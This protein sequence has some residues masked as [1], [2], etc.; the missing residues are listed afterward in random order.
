MKKLLLVISLLASLFS[1]MNNTSIDKLWKD[2]E[3]ARKA[4]KPQRQMEILSSIKETAV[5]ERLPWDF[6]SAGNKYVRVATSRNWKLR[7]SLDKSWREEILAFDEPILTFYHGLDGEA[8]RRDYAFAHKKALQKAHN[9]DF[10]A[11]DGYLTSRKFSPVLVEL[12]ENDWQGVLWSLTL[13]SR[14]DEESRAALSETLGG[15]YPQADFLEFARISAIHDDFSRKSEYL[16]F[17]QD[18]PGKAAA[19]LA[20]DE[21][22]QMEFA[23]LQ[24]EGAGEERYRALRQKCVD[25]QK[26]CKDFNGSE[27]KI[28]SC[29]TLAG[30]LLKTL[31]SKSLDINVEKGELVAVL[32]NLDSFEVTLSQGRTDI[33]KT[34]V[35]NPKR[36]FYVP[37]TLTL[38]LPD[39]PDGVYDVLCSSGKDISQYVTYDKYS[40][41]IARRRDASGLWILVTDA[42][43]G[44]PL[45]SADLVAKNSDGKTLASLEDFALDGY[46]LLPQAFASSLEG[47]SVRSPRIVASCTDAKGIV[48]SSKPLYP[49]AASEKSDRVSQEI[50][51][52]TDR[53]AFNP[54]DTVQFKVIVYQE[55]ADG[56]R[57]LV[58]LGTKVTVRL[59]DASGDE[60][61][62]VTLETGDFGSAAGSFVIPRSERN[63]RYSLN[64]ETDDAYSYRSIVVDDFV[65]P[66]FTLVFDEDGHLYHPGEKVEVTGTIRSYSGHSVSAARVEAQVSHY[67]EVL[68][69][70]TPI[71]GE[72]GRFSLSFVCDSEGYSV[73][74]VTVKV[75]DS[76]GETLEWSTQRRFYDDIPL[77]VSI[78]RHSD[79]EYLSRADD[80]TL[81]S[82]DTL[83]SSGTIIS[84]DTL[85]LHLQADFMERDGL[86]ARYAIFKS[87]AL[88]GSADGSSSAPAAPSST[89][90]SGSLSSTIQGSPSSAIPV[91]EGRTT[92][93]DSV[94]VDISSLPDGLYTLRCTASD[95]DAFGNVRSAER[96]QTFLL[97]R[98]GSSAFDGDLEYVFKVE[99]SVSGLLLR[100]G[101]G[102]GTGAGFGSGSGAGTGSGSG[103]VSGS[104]SGSGADALTVQ[105]GTSHYPMWAF[106]DLHDDRGVLLGSRLVHFDSP[107]SSTDAASAAATSA[108]C[109]VASAT[110]PATLASSA[111]GSSSAVSSAS[112]ASSPS[113]VETAGGAIGGASGRV[114]TVRFSLEGVSTG[115]IMLSVRYFRDFQQYSWSYTGRFFSATDELPLRFSR[116]RDRTSPGET[117]SLELQTEPGVECAAAVFD[118]STETVKSNAWNRLRSRSA[119]TI[120]V[121]YDGVAGVD[122]SRYSRLYAN[123]GRVMMAKSAA[124][125]SDEMLL[126]EAE[127]TFAEALP[128]AL[129]DALPDAVGSLAYS[130]DSGSADAL[131][132]RE[133]F[134]N[135]LAFKPFLRSDD[136]GK[137]SFDFTAAD[138]LSTYIVQIFA[139]TRELRSAVVRREAVVTI[140]VKVS[141]VEPQYLYAGDRYTLSASL[142]S[143]FD[144]PVT[145]LLRVDF[146]DG[147]DYKAVAPLY[148]LSRTVTV[149]AGGALGEAFDLG[150]VP[151][152]PALHSGLL[153]IKVSFVA[154]RIVEVSSGSS[155]DASSEV[156]DGVSSR[157][158]A[159]V[160]CSD[161]VFVTVPVLPA[162][163]TITEAHSSL[164]H[165]GESMDSLALQLRSE[166]VGVSGDAASVRT[167]SLLD[168]VR[169]AIPSRVEATS[170]NALALSEALY[171]RALAARLSSRGSGSRSASGSGLGLVASGSGSGSVSGSGSGSAPGDPSTSDALLSKLM[172]CRRADGGFSWFST[173]D[174]SP[175]VTAALLYR[176]ASARDRGMLS[177]AAGSTGSG[178]DYSFIPREVIE[179]AVR[180]LDRSYFG[181]DLPFWR[182]ALSMQQY[183][184]VR[185]LFASVPFD[186]SDFNRL[187][188]KDFAKDAREF[189]VPSSDRGLQGRILAKARRMRVL[190]ALSSSDDGLAL[191]RAFGIKLLTTKRLQTSL[192]RDLA[193][194]EEYAVQHR[195]G[196][197]Y[198]PNAVLPW[199]GLLESEAF[200]H[201]YI[202]DLL[203]DIAAASAD[204]GSVSVASAGSRSGDGLSSGALPGGALSSASSPDDSRLGDGL[205]SATSLYDSRSGDGLPGGAARFNGFCLKGVSDELLSGAADISEGIRLWLMVQKETQ[206]WGSDAAFV[207]ALATVLD[208]SDETLATSVVVLSATFDT[209]FEQ[210]RASGNGFTIER[211]FY[212][213]RGDASDT[214]SG[215]VAGSDSGSDVGSGGAAAGSS[216][217]A[218][219]GAS[220]LVELRDGDVLRVGDKVT[221]VYRIWNEENRSFVR[222]SAPRPASFRP[223][224]QLS[225]SFGGWFRSLR[226]YRSVLSDRTEYWYDAYPEEVTTVEESF[227]VTQSG[228]FQTPASVVES[229]YAP[230][231]RANAS[232][233]AP[234]QSQ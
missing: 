141:V 8:A 190:L 150:Q 225:G 189:L 64:A 108:S 95:A 38:S 232:G 163:Q 123:G 221:V 100:S 44:E 153:G 86:V 223:V 133:N 34:V 11:D 137:V 62:K 17:V 146:Y 118:K 6:Y 214:A 97:L 36:S 77:S 181:A 140:P 121:S 164:L 104:G 5:Q 48:R 149:P 115:S 230:H 55:D 73:Y 22:L 176:Y 76:T 37:D 157:P 180:Y 102:S 40:L 212:V 228:A 198:Y 70:E 126:E 92:V 187:R 26:K 188:V 21:L 15:A 14:E 59:E 74:A 234:I 215:S 88:P 47:K 204:S 119:L 155:V 218:S 177:A 68:S 209:P 162:V 79:G 220:A 80:G 158:S 197:W 91:L 72:D 117:C 145:G 25:F 27:A 168:M 60:V 135:T 136:A 186:A 172:E 109:A 81:I 203:R 13:R 29:C 184:S 78:G 58:P 61:G 130:L 110:D 167:I 46:T 23:S 207:E 205:S 103:A 156:S 113:A 148:S 216:N 222:I 69:R 32:R 57:S 114:Q 90:A 87:E 139:H 2:Y 202:A 18:R 56:V 35:E 224:E 231:Y 138:K 193:S 94:M 99:G 105:V 142:A 24:R 111:P 160:L 165:K 30:S 144:A 53:S 19:L 66:T 143:T 116:F 194:L 196:G 125:Y 52:L 151:G 7:D 233:A 131:A 213:E 208:A 191:A 195:S 50:I 185:A 170:D 82:S 93:P 43:S 154:D 166:F 54:E 45:R 147:A 227:Y 206:Q 96:S 178:S 71:V 161:A 75:T 3:S 33:F 28:A 49:G 174:S 183:L 106:V 98:D 132:V 175:I 63:G 128:N 41:S 226:G 122:R 199:R 192:A 134:A 229:L 124:F 101:S 127:G 12:L 4:D 200:A 169:E 51:I 65:L 173:M 39:L 217:S 42:L 120:P 67:G 31:G 211:R 182:G 107:L 129:P 201:S 179:A 84:S 9:A 159:P 210:V 89:S 219:N 112:S 171:V 83:I 1:G 10:Y 20:E 85:I 16:T 152:L